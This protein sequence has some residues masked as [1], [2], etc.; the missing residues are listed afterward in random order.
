MF[1]LLRNFVMCLLISLFHIW[2]LLALYF[3]FS[4]S[5]IV[6]KILSLLIYFALVVW[7]VWRSKSKMTSFFM[8]LVLFLV[9]AIWFMS[10]KPKEDGIYPPHLRLASVEFDGNLIKIDS[11]RNSTYR[12]EEDFDAHYYKETY[13]L[14]KIQGVDFFVNYWGIEKVAHTFVS[15][16]FADGKFLPVSVETRPQV[17]KVYGMLKGFFKQYELIYIWSTEQDLV[18]SRTNYRLEDVYLYRLNFTPVEARELIVD[19]LKATNQIAKEQVFYNTAIHSCTNTIGDHVLN[20]VP[21]RPFSIWDRRMLTGDVDQ[22]LYKN[23]WLE[24]YGKTFEE[25]RKDAYINP[26]AQSTNSGINFSKRIR[27]H[28]VEKKESP[29]ENKIK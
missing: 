27:T 28:L 26:R 8:S 9:V 16:R 19:M 4:T 24:I 15:F 7:I 14:D 12:S 13:D 2:S 10:I 17:G 25:L 5:F 23:G 18:K 21:S 20:A 11:I 1:K 3:C 6:I 22:R 29:H